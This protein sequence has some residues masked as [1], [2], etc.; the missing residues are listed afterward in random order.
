MGCTVPR[1]LFLNRGF[2]LAELLV[3]VAI[4]AYA[5]SGSMAL[6]FYCFFTNEMNRNLTAA[7]SHAQYIMEDIRNTTFSSISTNISGG[8][9]DFNTAGVTAAG[10]SALNSEAIDT[11]V[12][13]S[14]PLDVSVTVT[15]QDRRQRSRTKVLETLIGG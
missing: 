7:T 10:L 5:I 12:S 11:Q 1:K 3:S 8:T 13:G 15:W 6:F 9:W 14:N 4:L 2:T